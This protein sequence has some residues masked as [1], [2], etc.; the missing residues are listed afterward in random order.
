MQILSPESR[1]DEFRKQRK[2]ILQEASYKITNLIVSCSSKI[3]LY[4]LEMIC[5]LYDWWR[6]T[7]KLYK[8]NK[9]LNKYNIN[10]YNKG[11]LLEK[12]Y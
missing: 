2:L 12:C 3:K 11:L 10:K 7:C 9:E 1:Q 6:L 4:H 5:I 8:Y